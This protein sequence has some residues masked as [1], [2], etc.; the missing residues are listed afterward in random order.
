MP[1]AGSRGQSIDLCF[2]VIRIAHGQLFNVAARQHTEERGVALNV[3]V[4]D[5]TPHCHTEFSVKIGFILGELHLSRNMWGLL[6]EDHPDIAKSFHIPALCHEITLLH[7]FGSQ[8]I[9]N[10]PWEQLNVITIKFSNFHIV[11]CL[12]GYSHSHHLTTVANESR[13][14]G[15]Q[16]CHS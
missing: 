1:P 6:L 13:L 3:I 10:C 5:I 8:T 15:G 12:V 11:Y 16:K 7:V 4:T 9:L 14:V 2:D